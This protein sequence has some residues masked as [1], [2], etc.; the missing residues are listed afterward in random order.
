MCHCLSTCSADHRTTMGF[1]LN[2]PTAISCTLNRWFVKSRG[3]FIKSLDGKRQERIEKMY[4]LQ[5]YQPPLRT[6]Q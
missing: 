1:I 3:K 5:E 6:I 4:F 2:T